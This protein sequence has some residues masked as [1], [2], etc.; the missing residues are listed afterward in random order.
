MLSGVRVEIPKC[1]VPPT[2]SGAW[3]GAGGTVVFPSGQGPFVNPDPTPTPSLDEYLVA[4]TRLVSFASNL[5]ERFHS[6]W[7]EG[8]Q[9]REQAALVEMHGRRIAALCRGMG[10]I[11]AP[12]TIR[13]ITNAVSQVIRSRHAW[14]VEA[15]GQLE[16]CG[17]SLTPDLI[18]EEAV[19]R[20]AFEQV[21]AQL[22][23]I[24]SP[25]LSHDRTWQA[26]ILG[27]SLSFPTGWLPVR[28]DFEVVV[29][30]PPELQR[31]GVNAI[32]PSPRPNGTAV[33]LWT[34]RLPGTY[35][36]KEAMRDSRSALDRYGTLLETNDINI[37]GMEGILYQ[38]LDD[39]TGWK[40]ELAVFAPG[41]KGLF[42]EIACPLEV[43]DECASQARE[44]LRSLEFEN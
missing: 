34:V 42:F 35:G 25:D 15:A 31:M 44:I 13:D 17:T 14:T 9:P 3:Q 23:S 33:R 10:L 5:S 41:G 32:G 27:L 29:L 7:I 16:C 12:D 1:D 26:E 38:A 19:T 30:A 6:V 2:S 43:A 21:Q 24:G 39:E 40:V 4:A 37:A 18:E 11:P 28:S 36:L 22:E 20:R 8:D